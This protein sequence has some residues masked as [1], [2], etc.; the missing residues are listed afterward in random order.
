M[1]N[2]S[3]YKNLVS[4]DA[5]SGTVLNSFTSLDAYGIYAL[6]LN[7]Q[8]LFFGGDSVYLNGAYQAFGCFPNGSQTPTS[9]N[10]N[11]FGGPVDQFALSVDGS[12]YV[13]GEF[14]S[15]GNDNR[16]YLA[17]FNRSGPAIFDAPSRANP[18]L[19]TFTC[20]RD[21]RYLIQ[22]SSDLRNWSALATNTGRFSVVAPPNN[23]YNFFRAL[24]Q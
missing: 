5:S 15:I 17:A 16:P 7:D 4:V 18:Q 21:E 14:T 1:V 19:I 9:W 3:N 2:G 20:D 10:P 23:S 8:N 12:I 22:G 24:K 11:A 6:A 13:A